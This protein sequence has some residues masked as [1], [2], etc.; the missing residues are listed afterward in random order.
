[1]PSQHSLTTASTT[2]RNSGATPGSTRL[3]SLTPLRFFAAFAVFVTHL[4]AGVWY[5]EVG[6]NGEPMAMFMMHLSLV[7]VE[8]FFLLSGF[9]LTW[10]ARPSD[11]TRS[12]WRRRFVKI[13]PNHLVTWI[14]GLALLLAVGQQVTFAQG[15]TTFFLVDAWTPDEH[16]RMGV[17]PPSWSLGCEAF[18]YLCF[19]LLLRAIEKIRDNLLWPCAAGCFVVIAA[20]PPLAM[21]LTPDSPQWSG[22][23]A[24]WE[25]IWLSYNFPVTRI[26]E[27]ILGIVLARIV[28]KRL[29]YPTGFSI[30]LV[31]MPVCFGLAML[32]PYPYGAA[33]LLVIPISLLVIATAHTDIAG[34]GSFLRKRSMVVL[35]DWSFAF[36][37]V[38]FL[39]INYTYPMIDP[40]KDA[41]TLVKLAASV[42]LFFL[43]LLAAWGLHTAVERPAMRRWSRS[44]SARVRSRTPAGS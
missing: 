42:V 21:A 25:Q 8:F 34:R 35:G 6:P 5:A 1:M 24:T 18:F 31:A 15:W 27:F 37:L 20:I 4:Y 3:D 2:P 40:E 36:Y 38:H 11:D 44:R 16:V 28:I 43:S 32:L 26:F 29:W 7:G 9:V 39:I 41:G 22:L 10:S 33:A 19:P 30:A 17:N 23:H 14:I 12:F 13:F